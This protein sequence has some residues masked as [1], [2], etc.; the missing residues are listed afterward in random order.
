MIDTNLKSDIQIVINQIP[1]GV[2]FD[3][4]YVIQ[5][6]LFNYSTHYQENRSNY[7]H[8][9]TF[10]SDISKEIKKICG[11]YLPSDSISVNVHL[12]SS[13]DKCWRK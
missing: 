5:Q 6:L 1:N 9:N 13:P 4:H 11:P 10:H 7:H 8:I 2:I 12:N 3:A